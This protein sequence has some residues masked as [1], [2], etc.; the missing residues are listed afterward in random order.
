MV[1]L[2]TKTS[3]LHLSFIESDTKLHFWS[4]CNRFKLKANVTISLNHKIGLENKHTYKQTNK[5]NYRTLH[6]NTVTDRRKFCV[7]FGL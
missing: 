3:L 4:L 5:L 1:L 7:L 6:I 2:Q